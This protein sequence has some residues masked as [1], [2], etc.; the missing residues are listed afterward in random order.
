MHS[1]Y[2]EQLAGSG[3]DGW[4]ALKLPARKTALVHALVI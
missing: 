4:N 1:V 3:V 2:E